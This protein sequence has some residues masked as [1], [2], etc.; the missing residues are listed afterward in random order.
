MNV[1]QLGEGYY[2]VTL[3]ETAN[4]EEVLRIENAFERAREDAA[5]RAREATDAR[6][7]N[8]AQAQRPPRAAV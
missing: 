3:P 7:R 8:S 2:R 5:Q 1:E 4:Q 6:G